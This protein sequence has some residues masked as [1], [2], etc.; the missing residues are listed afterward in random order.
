MFRSHRAPARALAFAGLAAAVYATGACSSSSSKGLS[1]SGDDGSDAAASDDASM[2]QGPSSD[3][4]ASTGIFQGADSG[5]MGTGTCQTGTYTGTFSCGF[6]YDPDAS[7]TT[8]DLGADGGI[9]TITGTISFQLSQSISGELGQDTASGH[10]QIGAGF[11]IVGD[12]DLSGTL[13][14]STGAFTGSLLN[15][16]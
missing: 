16:A 4:D 6:I 11:F 15:G 9:V 1:G 13:D 2:D 7:G 8:T 12:A 3:D 10:I 14:C 5:G